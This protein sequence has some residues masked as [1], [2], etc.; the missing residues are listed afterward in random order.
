M[1]SKKELERYARQLILKEL[2]RA[3]QEKLKRSHTVVIGC[4]ATGSIIANNLARAGMGRLTLVDRDVVNL[5]NLHR[6]TL[7]T[8]NDLGKP[9]PTVAKK[10]LE[11][12][13]PSI[14]ISPRFIDCDSSNI[15][16]LIGSADVVCDG[17]DNMETRYA[18]ND[19][20]V[21]HGIP[22][23][24]VGAVATHGMTMPVMPGKTACLRCV[25]PLPPRSG[26]LPTSETVGIIGMM[27]AIIGSMGSVS[28]VKILIGGP[29]TVKPEMTIYDCWSNEFTKVIVKRN[30]KCRCCSGRHFDFL[31]PQ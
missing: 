6:Q 28:A 13:N 1:L 25:F 4:G 27:P 22:W 5:D 3:G 20:C 17:T 10:M 21:K 29:D 8:E 14:K 2:G 26:T 31:Q 30:R 19:A 7:Y 15:E 12:A 16:S 24:Y 11:A 9:K 18:I 23:V